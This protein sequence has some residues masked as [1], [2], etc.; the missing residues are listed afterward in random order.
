M[1]PFFLLL[2][3]ALITTGLLGSTAVRVIRASPGTQARRTTNLDLLMTSIGKVKIH[4]NLVRVH[5]SI[6]NLHRDIVACV[7]EAFEKD[8]DT[9]LPMSDIFQQ[10]FG[11]NFSIV[12]ASFKQMEFKLVEIVRDNII[13]NLPDRT[14]AGD[15][16]PQ[17]MHFFRIFDLVTGLEYD[18]MGVLELMKASLS[19][20]IQPQ[21]LLTLM[22][23]TEGSVNDYNRVRKLFQEEK[24][25]LKEYFKMKYEEFTTKHDCTQGESV[26]EEMDDDSL[27]VEQEELV[28]TPDEDE[29]E[30]SGEEEPAEGEEEDESG[31]EFEWNGFD[32][33]DSSNGN[34]EDSSGHLDSTYDSSQER[35]SP[36]HE[37]LE[38]DYE[39]MRPQESDQQQTKFE[40]GGE[41]MQYDQQE[42]DEYA[43]SAPSQKEPAPQKEEMEI[44]SY[45][46][47]P[48]DDGGSSDDSPNEWT[49]PAQPEESAGEAVAEAPQEEQP[50]AEGGEAAQGEEAGQE[51]GEGRRLYSFGTRESETPEIHASIKTFAFQKTLYTDA[52]VKKSKK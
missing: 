48:K 16:N 6:R 35:G 44:E 41:D 30:E 36:Q 33:S 8:C 50:V 22:E 52:H 34:D 19:K 40:D 15:K 20:R 49:P 11:E 45:Y 26:E 14:C 29:S 1:K 13:A 12:E 38:E 27:D 37:D 42:S 17:C 4:T 2:F 25:Y 5:Q 24:L 18:V 43:V 23:H 21:D 51:G 46:V 3:M 9:V 10:C 7:D 28:E 31:S 39:P 32:M 47:P